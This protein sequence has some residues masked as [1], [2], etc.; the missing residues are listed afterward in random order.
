MRQQHDRQIKS[1]S[2][3]AL[4]AWSGAFVF[5]TVFVLSSCTGGRYD[6]LL[7]QADSL[8]TVKPDS[9]W[10]LLSAVDSADIARQSRSTQMRYQLLRAEAQ[11]KLYID[12]T[13]DSVMRQ[14]VQYYDRRGS[15]NER[16]KA[17]YLL[18]CCYRDMHEAPVALLT[19]EDAV[20]CADTTAADCDYASLFRVYGQ[21]AE[22][23][24]WQHLP[25]KQLEALKGFSKFAI[26]TGDTLNYLLGILH[27]NS[28]Y[29]ALGDTASIFSN[30]EDARCQYLKL[31]LIQ[32]AARVYPT[33]I[34]VAVET[35]QYERAKRMMDIYV[36]KSGLFDEHA[37]IL[38]RS[39]IQY[40]YYKGV[41]YVGIHEEDSAE[42][43]FRKLMVD[44]TEWVNANRGLLAVYQSKCNQD[45]II[46]YSK[47]L[48]QSL[49]AHQKS[50]Q[51][52]AIMQAQGM[53][54]YHRQQ[55]LALNQKLRGDRFLF[56]LGYI[57]IF[58]VTFISLIILFFVYRSNQKKRQIQDLFIKY[59]NA[60]RDMGIKENELNILREHLHIANETASLL[61]AKE[62]DFQRIKKA[63]TE[64]EVLF[65]KLKNSEKQ[66]ALENCDIVN[67]FHKISVPT[68]EH[69]GA[70]IIHRPARMAT[71]EEW[72]ELEQVTKQCLPHFH[73]RITDNLT[74]QEF[75]LCILFR[76]NFKGS[77][78]ANLLGTSLSRISNAKKSANQKLF[79]ES[80]SSSLIKNL[81]RL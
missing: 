76:L 44:S 56:L 64:Y 57:S 12:F 7:R 55:E 34:H 20:A 69:Q 5:V 27:C 30:S 70:R 48:E 29:Y 46:K 33:P 61:R 31:G 67:L 60:I 2:A 73:N 52:T 59:T 24:K 39:R 25:E 10:T 37:N 18:G 40:Y 41:Y 8:L 16:L 49:I 38:D 17:H 28:A 79:G 26:L 43:Q 65:N 4:L 14:V 54:D 3:H 68:S 71:E 32:E 13:T 81:K 19:W 74:N 15:R 23:Y 45:S 78:V 72:K 77:E 62:E 21:M 6:A 42:A 11:N 80:D 36:Q 50:I 9:A 53:Y 66:A 51:T 63:S 75:R 35:G 1:V 58:A 47:L 22:V